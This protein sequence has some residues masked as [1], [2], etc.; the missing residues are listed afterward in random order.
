MAWLHHVNPL[1]SRLI[2]FFSDV[3]DGI[4]NNT[5]LFGREQIQEIYTEAHQTCLLFT[6]AQDM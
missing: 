4:I 6:I 2:L 1:K 5:M 3:G